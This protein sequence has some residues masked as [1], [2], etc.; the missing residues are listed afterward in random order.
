MYIVNAPKNLPITSEKIE[1][2][3]LKRSCSVLVLLSSL[4]LR[5]VRIGKTTIIRKRM[6]EK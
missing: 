4:K 3:E 6:M 1:L 5:I 2:G